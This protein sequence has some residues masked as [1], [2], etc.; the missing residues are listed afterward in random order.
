M[1]YIDNAKPLRRSQKK[2][3]DDNGVPDRNWYLWKHV[4]AAVEP[5]QPLEQY[6]MGFMALLH[7]RLKVLGYSVK[8]FKIEK[9][10]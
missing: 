3:I 4:D 9:K 7:D 2:D 5:D 10:Y 8:V 1:A 6:M